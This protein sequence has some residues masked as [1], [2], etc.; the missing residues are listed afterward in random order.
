MR[1]TYNGYMNHLVEEN[2]PC[3]LVPRCGPVEKGKAREWV[4]PAPIEATKGIR[5]IPK[6]HKHESQ[7]PCCTQYFRVYDK[8]GMDFDKGAATM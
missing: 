8:V 7:I 6:R 3:L 1:A 4:N 2:I 5:N